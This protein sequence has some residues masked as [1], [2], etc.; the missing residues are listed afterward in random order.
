M[1]PGIYRWNMTRNLIN[2]LRLWH[3]PGIGPRSLNFLQEKF[4]HHP[5][6]LFESDLSEL[7][8][9]NIPERIARAISNDRS[10]EYH[11]DLEWLNAEEDRHILLKTDESYPAL[12]SK[13]PDAPPILYLQGQLSALKHSFRLAIVGG[14]KC[15]AHG[16]LIADEFARQLAELGITIVSGLARGIDAHAHRATLGSTRGYT[17]AVLAN[18]LDIIYPPDHRA[19]A[20]Q[21]EQHGALIS[22]FPP[23]VKPLPGHF[24]RRNRIISGLSLGTIVIEASKKSGSLITAQFA[25]D[26]GRELFAV[27]GPVNNPLNSGS[28]LLIQQGGK[29]ATNIEDILVEFEQ[30]SAFPGLDNPKYEDSKA[31]SRD[32]LAVLLEFIEHTPTSIDTIIEKSGL[33]PDQVCSMLTEL[34]IGGRVVCDAYGQYSRI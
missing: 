28:H 6:Q 29:L 13:I 22:E 17:I 14:R 5:Q 8:S 10:D 27:P 20:K 2:W 18:G 1:F 15:S 33:T 16:K 21:I 23:G 12:L 4:G 31:Q 9:L 34:E 11:Q 26:Q 25:L 7:I 24:P 3:I 19:L 30:L 32:N